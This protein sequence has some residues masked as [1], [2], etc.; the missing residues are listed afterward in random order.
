[1]VSS[2]LRKNNVTQISYKL[3]SPIWPC[4]T[5]QWIPYFDWC[6]WTKAECV[7]QPFSDPFSWS[8]AILEQLHAIAALMCMCPWAIPLGMITMRKSNH[9]FAFL[10][11]NHGDFTFLLVSDLPWLAHL[12]G[13]Q[14]RA[15]YW[16]T[17]LIDVKC[18]LRQ[19]ALSHGSLLLCYSHLPLSLLDD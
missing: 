17:G 5:G 15:F 2:Q 8:M 10:S 9:G 18:L 13:H 6:L 11:V 4:G 19:L 1:M 12:V 7:F 14:C 3:E 16:L